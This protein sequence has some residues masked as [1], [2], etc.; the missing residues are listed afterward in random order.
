MRHGHAW[1]EPEPGPEPGP[2]RGLEPE[3]ELE[4]ELEPELELELEPELESQLESQ[5]E[6]ERL[7]RLA[8]LAPANQRAQGPPHQEEAE[9]R[10]R[11]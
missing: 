9:Q 1:F 4:L 6:G 10:R 11:D 5:L 3:L 2:E 7:S 8:S